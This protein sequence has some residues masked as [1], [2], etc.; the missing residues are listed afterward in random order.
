[1]S[2]LRI[3]EPSNPDTSARLRALCDRSAETPHEIEAA[4]RAVIA[5]VR[6]RGDAAVR[7]LTAKFERRTL[8]SF[9]LPRVEWDALAA[10]VAP[11][12][13]AAIQRATARVRA[14]HERE[15]YTSFEIADGGLRVGCR[16]APLA[17]VGLYVPGG[18]ARYPSTVYMTAVPAKVAGVAEVV[19]TTPGPSPETIA[20]AI[21]AGVDRV[22]VIGGAQAVAA[23]AY[24]TETV[25]R[26]DKIVGPGNAYVAAAKR[27]VFGDVG[28]DSI[29]GPTELVVAADDSVDPAWVAADLLAQA[30]HDKLAVPVLIALGLDVAKRVAVEVDR[31]VALLP[32]R[33]IAEAALRDGGAIFLA[34]DVD[35]VV[36]LVNLLAPEHTELA[37]RDARAVSERMTTSGA[38]FLGSHTPESVGD[39]VAGPSHVLPTGGSARFFSP[40]GVGDFLKRTSIIE[41]D[42]AALDAQGRDIE[43]IAE[44][45]GLHAHGRAASIR[46][47]G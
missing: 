5:D 2:L 21:E 31:Q 14:F 28:I 36:R 20:A 3:Y 35:D 15:K 44:V 46:T 29:A 43:A 32:R 10:K 23:L 45:E 18:T 11:D 8:T 40:L 37:M 33:E 24:G 13:R 39:Y 38:I 34:K 12:V 47:R 42:A 19:M 17:R 26:V 6:K 27:L 1:M 22:L 9:E 7:E 4:A 30:E 41:Y 16:F 25:P